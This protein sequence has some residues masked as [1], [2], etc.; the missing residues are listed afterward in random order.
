[1][2]PKTIYIVQNNDNT[3]M[4][5]FSTTT[6]AEKLIEIGELMYREGWEIETKTLDKIPEF[7]YTDI[8]KVNRIIKD[9][10]NDK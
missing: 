9:L 2:T 6:K 10:T 4:G 5:I 3:I 1:M 8:E 7:L